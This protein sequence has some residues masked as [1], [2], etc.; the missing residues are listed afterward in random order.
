MKLDGS[1]RVYAG[2]CVIGICCSLLAPVGQYMGTG[3]HPLR[4][5]GM[6]YTVCGMRMW[7]DGPR[8]AVCGMTDP[9]MWYAVYGMTDSSVY[10]MWYDEPLFVSIGICGVSCV[11]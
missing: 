6:R 5:Y 3:L 7:Y 10:G 2:E 1:G 4:V 8:Y 9:G 11:I